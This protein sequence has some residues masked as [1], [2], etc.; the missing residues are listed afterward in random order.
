MPTRKGTVR[1]TRFLLPVIF[2]IYYITEITQFK[3]QTLCNTLVSTLAIPKH[4]CRFDVIIRPSCVMPLFP[5]ESWMCSN[6]STT[7]NQGKSCTR[8]FV[9]RRHRKCTL[10][11]PLWMT[12]KNSRWTRLSREQNVLPRSALPVNTRPYLESKRL[13]FHFAPSPHTHSVQRK[14]VCP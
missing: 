13:H 8:S 14:E 2:A 4:N 9:A 11:L 7:F 3:S 6:G 10:C 5:A 12:R 1:V